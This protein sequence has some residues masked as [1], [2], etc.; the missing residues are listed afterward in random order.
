MSLPCKVYSNVP[1]ID[2]RL[3]GLGLSREVLIQ[4]VKAGLLARREHTENHPKTSAGFNT[5][6]ETVRSLRDQLVSGGWEAN[7][8][9]NQGLTSNEELRVSI[10]VVPGDAKTG[11]QDSTPSTRSS[12]GPRTADAIRA[13]GTGYLFKEIE[14]QIAALMSMRL[15]GLWLLL[16]FVNEARQWVQSELSR[17]TQ[18]TDGNRPT[19]WSERILLP[20][21]DFSS[22]PI[23]SN[24][25]DGPDVQKS[26]EIVIEVKRRA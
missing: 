16:V 13:N 24:R 7:N 14:E 10:A 23:S 15:D 25:T 2:S 8:E 18:M 4:A 1:D 11:R 12:R 3:S 20:D 6:S 5:W 17:A 22:T 9:A 21:I 26:P 19:A